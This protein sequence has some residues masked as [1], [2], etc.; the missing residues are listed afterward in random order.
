MIRVIGTVIF[1][2]LCGYILNL[3][4]PTLSDYSIFEPTDLPFEEENDANF[5][6]I[7]DIKREEINCEDGWSLLTY[8]TQSWC[9]SSLRGT[10]NCCEAIQDCSSLDALPGFWP[11]AGGTNYPVPDELLELGEP[12]IVFVVCS[13]STSQNKFKCIF[14]CFDKNGVRV[15]DYGQTDE[16]DMND[17]SQA[18]CEDAYDQ[19][20]NGEKYGCG[21]LCKY[22]YW[23]WKNPIPLP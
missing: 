15:Y 6:D 4:K 13:N 22:E 21:T 12:L 5:T 7:L 10:G 9:V 16:F 18:R 2:P 20:C 8:L 14:N 1:L 17:C 3:N 19:F 11:H 23:C